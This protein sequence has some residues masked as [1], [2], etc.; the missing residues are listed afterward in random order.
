MTRFV[1]G[2]AAAVP[3]V[4]VTFG[5][6]SL[7]KTVIKP[8]QQ[9]V[10]ALAKLPPQSWPTSVAIRYASPIALR[11][12]LGLLLAAGATGGTSAA[13]ESMF[14]RPTHKA[15]NARQKTRT[16]DVGGT[17]S[18]LPPLSDPPHSQTRRG[19]AR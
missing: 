1:G 4:V 11:I 12:G 9:D 2:V 17:A 7:L 15:L 3:A 16:I 14:F 8:A 6:N 5:V 13:V 10:E 18:T 19:D